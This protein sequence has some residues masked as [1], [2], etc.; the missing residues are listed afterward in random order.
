MRRILNVIHQ[1]AACDMASV[2]FGPTI[3]RTDIF[4]SEDS[5]SIAEIFL[6]QIKKTVNK[7]RVLYL[8]DDKACKA[9][10]G[11]LGLSVVVEQNVL[12]FEV[13]VS[14]VVTVEVLDGEHDAV[15]N[16]TSLVL[17]K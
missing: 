10:V 8:V 6:R 5:I 12:A 14:D 2:H 4:G 9:E 15:E 16:G 17:W 13:P 11:E 3:R 1:E 7:C